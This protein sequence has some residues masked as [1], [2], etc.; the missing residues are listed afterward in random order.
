MWGQTLPETA[1]TVTVPA[2][3]RQLAACAASRQRAGRFGA[4]ARM[5]VKVV[6]WH[7]SERVNLQVSV[8]GCKLV[9]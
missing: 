1:G 2:A 5:F 7:V 4:W 9:I 8:S 3:L 6:F